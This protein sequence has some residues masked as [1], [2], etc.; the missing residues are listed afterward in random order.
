M[1]EHAL[2][3]GADDPRFAYG[4][5][6]READPD[7]VSLPDQVAR[8]TMSTDQREALPRFS[9]TIREG[10]TVEQVTAA[11]RP[12][13]DV[14]PPGPWFADSSEGEAARATARASLARGE[15]IRLEGAHVGVVGDDIPDRFR[16]WVAS[17]GD[18]SG[19]LEIGISEPLELTVTLAL[20]E[21]GS[22]SKSIPVYRVPSLPDANLAY[23]GVIGVAVLAIDVRDAESASGRE[24][25]Q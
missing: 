18:G 15:P 14:V 8:Y 4:V 17:P 12:G 11:P 2:R 19:V 25:E 22:I 13:V 6:G 21:L 7:D 24:R 23:A 16:E 10:D 9:L 3:I 20:P 5:A 1:A